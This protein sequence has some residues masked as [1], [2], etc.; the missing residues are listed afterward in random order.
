MK[1]IC[2]F[3]QDER[4]TNSGKPELDWRGERQSL[5]NGSNPLAMIDEHAV[6]LIAWHP[7]HTGTQ[8]LLDYMRT[9]NVHIAE[10]VIEKFRKS[11]A[12]IR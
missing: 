8:N 5:P 7:Q 2:I 12:Y 3:E 6:C 11:N 4:F 10:N 9:L 1:N